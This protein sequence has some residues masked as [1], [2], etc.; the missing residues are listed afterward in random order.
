MYSYSEAQVPHMSPCSCAVYSKPVMMSLVMMSPIHVQL[1]RSPGS[2]HVPIQL[3]CVLLAS[4]NES[5]ICTATQKPRFPTCPHTAALCT[6]NLVTMS[7]VHVQLLRSPGSPHV[8]VQLTGYDAPGTC[9]AT[10]KPRFPT[11][12]CTAVLC[13]MNW[14]R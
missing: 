13:T 4:Y 9:T 8:P 10:Q 1:L 2:S 12:L 11:Y 5:R 14:L 3:C 7:L 6:P